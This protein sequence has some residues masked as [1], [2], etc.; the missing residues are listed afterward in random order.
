MDKNAFLEHHKEQMK[1]SGFWSE[2]SRESVIRGIESKFHTDVI[3]H[4][5]IIDFVTNEGKVLIKWVDRYKTLSD[6]EL[7]SMYGR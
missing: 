1:V 7:A 4:M 3:R 2:I 6:E 5:T